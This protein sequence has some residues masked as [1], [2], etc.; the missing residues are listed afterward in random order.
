MCE[1]AFIAEAG[2]KGGNCVIRPLFLFGE[3]GVHLRG[4]G[5]T[6]VPHDFHYLGFGVGYFGYFLQN[7]SSFLTKEPLNNYRLT[8]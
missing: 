8:A 6:L 3:L 7:I 2:Q 4:G 1:K 5:L